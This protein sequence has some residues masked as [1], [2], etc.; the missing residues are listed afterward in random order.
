MTFTVTYRD[1]SGAR[2]EEAIEAADRA[3]CVA[4]CRARGILP[5]AIRE[6]TK[7]LKGIKG[8]KGLKGNRGNRG[9]R[10]G[11]GINLVLIK[12]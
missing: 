3:A 4:A 6:G 12:N 10:G 11:G 1:K 7:G 5:L 2:R 8:D 9:F